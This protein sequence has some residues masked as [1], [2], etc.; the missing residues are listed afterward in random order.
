[1]INVYKRLHAESQNM[2]QMYGGQFS[3]F[4][5]FCVRKKKLNKYISKITIVSENLLQI[6]SGKRFTFD[7]VMIKYILIF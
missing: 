4:L 2:R 1:M 7:Q 3:N 6:F 5:I